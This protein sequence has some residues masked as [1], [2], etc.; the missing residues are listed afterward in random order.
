VLTQP[1][2]SETMSVYGT[3]RYIAP[4]RLQGGPGDFRADVFS[5]GALWYT[6]ITAKTLPDPLEADPRVPL[7]VLPLPRRSRPCSAGRS[8]AAIAGTTARRR[9]PGRSGRP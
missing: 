4:E 2:A 3:S 5:V 7:E 8:T 6:M 1:E 9:W